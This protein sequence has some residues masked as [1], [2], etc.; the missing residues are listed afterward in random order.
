MAAEFLPEFGM[1][2]ECGL[3]RHSPEQLEAVLVARQEY[4]AAPEPALLS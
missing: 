1:S 2:T 4:S 3:G